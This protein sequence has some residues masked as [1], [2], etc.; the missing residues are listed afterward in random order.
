[1]TVWHGPYTWG[2]WNTS[3]AKHIWTYKFF[4]D[5]IQI[6]NIFLT[7]WRIKD[8]LGFD[9]KRYVPGPYDGGGLCYDKAAMVW[10]KGGGF[11]F[12]T[13]YAGRHSPDDGGE[14]L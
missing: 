1:R 9:T 8:V 2:F 6:V 5:T 7:V 11:S 12:K 4:N 3:T 10:K 14:C 13:L